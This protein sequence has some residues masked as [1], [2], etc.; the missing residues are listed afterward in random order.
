MFLFVISL[1]CIIV[2]AGMFFAVKS[3]KFY[4]KKPSAAMICAAVC[5]AAG[6][7][8]GIGSFIKTVP[9]G[10]T[11]IVTTFGNVEEYTYEAGV[12]FDAPWHE[13]IK[14]D[15][16]NQKKRIDLSCF[17]S[18]I[19][20]V[21]VIYTLNYQIQKNNAQTIYKT[22]GTEYYQTV[23]EPRVQEAVKSVMAKYTA[24]ELLSN[25]TELSAEIRNILTE[26]LAS[27]HV[28]VLDTSLENLDFSDAFTDAVE[29]KQV[30]EQKA[31][32]A[33][34]EQEQKTMEAEAAAKRAAIEAKA[35]ADVAIIA[36]NADLDVQKI[37]ADAAEYA[38]QKDAAVIGQTR[39][40]IAKNPDALTDEDV[41]HLLVYYYILAW[42]GKLPETYIGSEDFY[43]MLAALATKSEK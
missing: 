33:Q 41:E 3:K 36:A 40:I 28:D 30:A 43:A 8:G 27:Y 31:K 6:L 19:Q 15:N 2:A 39:D 13:V 24:E 1:I 37:Q 20:E 16:R 22:I 35:A 23:I 17:S 4:I 38:G 21:N 26:K 12:H 14:M 9:T 18:D 7:A 5:L 42:D 11:G 29:A 25:R 32:Q 10:H 34:I